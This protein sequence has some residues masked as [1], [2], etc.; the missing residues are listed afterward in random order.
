MKK[1]YLLFALVCLALLLAA[2]GGAK[3]EGASPAQVTPSVNTPAPSSAPTPEAAPS[4]APTET[5][6]PS[7][8]TQTPEAEPSR[9]YAAFLEGDELP[10]HCDVFV[11]Y[12]SEYAV[13]IVYTSDGTVTDFCVL[14]LMMTDFKDGKPVYEEKELYRQEQLTPDCP[15]VVTLTFVGDLPNNGISYVDSAGETHRFSVSTSGEDGSL[16]LEAY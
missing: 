8:P 10:T 13:K 12:D 11:A 6:E 7:A 16:I 15:L 5:P 2:C 1:T 14:S 4:E 9:V 3:T